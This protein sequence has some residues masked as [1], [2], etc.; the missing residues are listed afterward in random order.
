MI[1]NASQL[2]RVVN[3]N[4]SF[5]LEATLQSPP[6][7]DDQREG[8]AA[9]EAAER[10]LRGQVQLADELID[11]KASN[12]VYMTRDM[13][14]NIED[15]VTHVTGWHGF[16][17]ELNATV[18]YEGSHTIRG[19]ADAVDIDTQSLT[20]RICDFKYGWR[21]VEV[22]PN[23]QLISYAIALRQ[24]HPEL[25]TFE[26]TIVQ[27][28]PFHRAGP[29]RTHSMTAQ[30]VD[31]YMHRLGQVLDTRDPKT[32]NTGAHCRYCKAYPTCSA[33]NAAAFNAV[34]LAYNTATDVV[35]NE[36]MSQTVTDLRRA[37]QLLKEKIDVIEQQAVD[38]INDGSFVPGYSV[39]A[40]QGNYTWND[41]IDAAMIQAITGVDPNEVSLM[42]PAKL[43]KLGA[44]ADV[45]KAITNRPHRGFKLVQTSG[46]DA[47]FQTAKKG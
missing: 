2:D 14:W 37:Q 41:G 39:Q 17:I 31:S 25:E 18:E 12:G 9:H 32:L 44:N 19:R 20:G 34:D 10:I 45:V 5:E 38:R 23:L 35:S 42:T 21:V 1:V 4:G 22:Y 46:A 33:I 43:K 30:E 47:A 11:R 36:A 13:I 40:T 24:K 29:V 28:R 16:E 15:Y 7:T 26:L 6:K 3:C 8:D 27:P